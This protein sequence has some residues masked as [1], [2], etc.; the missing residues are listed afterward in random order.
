MQQLPIAISTVL[1]PKRVSSFL[2][3]TIMLA[4]VSL[5]YGQDVPAPLSPTEANE[6]YQ[7]HQPRNMDTLIIQVE[8]FQQE[9]WS[10]QE[11]AN[12]ELVTDFVQHIMNNHDFDYIMT[13]YGDQPYAQHN[14]SMNDGIEGVVESVKGLQKRY[15]DFTYDVKHIHV[16]GE[17]VIFHSHSTV[18]KKHRG[19]DQKGFN[20][21]DTWRVQDGKIVEHWDAIQPLNGFMRFYSWMVGGAIR[22]GN[23]VF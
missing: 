17:Y 7:S 1:R 4:S 5:S 20:I 22:N 23:G 12:V 10:A 6:L 8:N 18:K 15:P 16:D 3:G 13:Q 19:N 9:N 2:I 11:L 14:R 21:M